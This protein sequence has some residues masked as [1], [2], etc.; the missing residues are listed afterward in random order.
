M[1][2]GWLNYAL[3]SFIQTCTLISQFQLVEWIGRCENFFLLYLIDPDKYFSKIFYIPHEY[4]TI[5]VHFVI[6]DDYQ[7]SIKVLHY[8]YLPSYYIYARFILCTDTFIGNIILTGISCT[9]YLFQDL[10]EQYSDAIPGPDMRIIFESKQ[11]SLEVPF[12]LAEF[13][14]WE[15]TPLKALQVLAY[16]HAGY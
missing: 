5:D 3:K 14:N 4:G 1:S 2:F 8:I 9:M 11:I 10:L 15:I 16:N 13:K 12:D 7:L 6:I